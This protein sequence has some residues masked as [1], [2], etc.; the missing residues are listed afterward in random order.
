M[1]SRKFRTLQIEE[2]E[3]CVRCVLITAR[4]VSGI[5]HPLMKPIPTPAAKCEFT[6]SEGP[7]KTAD[8]R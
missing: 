2:G 7:L 8:A 6:R 5:N 3:L 4:E 1:S